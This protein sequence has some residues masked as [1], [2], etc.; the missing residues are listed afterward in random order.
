MNRFLEDASTPRSPSE[1]MAFTRAE[2]WRGALAAWCTFMI[3]L[4]L[5]LIVTG[6]AQSGLPWDPPLSMIAL[7]LMFGLPIGGLI[8]A[9]VTVTASPV[10]WVVSR[11]LRRTRS[12]VVHLLTYA[13]FGAALGFAV[14]MLGVLVTSG[15]PGYAFTSPTAWLTPLMCALAVAGG[16]GWAARRIH[17]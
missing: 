1:P 10:A 15:D 9:V 11:A 16:C 12:V 3:L 17:H 14:L 6:V 7:Y 2:F 4:S 8:A 5:T 13:A